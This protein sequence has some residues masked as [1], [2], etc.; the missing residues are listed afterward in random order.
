[1]HKSI[2][3][4]LVN[5][6]EFNHVHI[7]ICCFILNIKAFQR[8]LASR[9]KTYNSVIKSGRQCVEEQKVEDPA[10]LSE[11]LDDLVARW[12]ALNMMSTTKQERLDNALT[13][14]E[15]FET[16]V[17]EELKVLK[18]VDARLRSFG[19][20]ADNADG[21]NRQIEEMEVIRLVLVLSKFLIKQQNV[22][23]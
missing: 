19:P 5:V 16:G 15:E 17:K 13:L 22:D 11:T 8:D 9:M 20:A 18:G 21:V 4:Y 3:V 23:L 1:M 14:A 2:N 12:D 10:S 6:Q 7:T